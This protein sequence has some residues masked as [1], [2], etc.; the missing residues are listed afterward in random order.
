MHRGPWLDQR[1]VFRDSRFGWF[2]HFAPGRIWACAAG[3]SSRR[4]GYFVSCVPLVHLLCISGLGHRSHEPRWMLTYRFN[5]SSSRPACWI[6][7]T[8][9]VCSN[10]GLALGNAGTIIMSGSLTWTLIKR[11]AS[12]VKILFLSS[13]EAW[14][15][16][17]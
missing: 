2:T 1:S 17:R 4:Y 13:S 6:A 14:Q 5:S 9:G 10:I 16:H 15:S 7:G 12:V 8:L 11:G 3:A